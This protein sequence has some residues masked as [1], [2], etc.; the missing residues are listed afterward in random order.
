MAGDEPVYSQLWHSISKWDIV[1]LVLKVMGVIY[2]Y[3]HK[4]E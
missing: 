1:I 4:A 2:V 3:D